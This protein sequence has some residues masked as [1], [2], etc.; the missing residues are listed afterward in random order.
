VEVVRKDIKNLHVG[1]Y[2]PSGR[3]RVA[4]PLRLGDDA[5]RL[6]VISRLGWIRRRQAEFEQ[7]DRQSQRQL[8]TGESH[9]FQGRRYRLDLVAHDGPPSVYRVN[10]TIMELRVRPGTDSTKREAVLQKWYR[11]RLRELLPQLL[12]KWERKVDVTVAEVR[13]KRMKTRWGSCNTAAGRIW[14]NLELAKKPPACLEYIL[15]HE[16]VHLIERHH[17]D[18]FRQCMDRVMPQWRLRREE[19]NR[20]PLSH[21]DWRY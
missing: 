18:R 8:V 12:A 5:V 9:Y 15:V 6:A 2:P 20:A 16:M 1:V 13:I 10:N 3:V 21:E 7:Q 11:G 17:T 19:L 14:L 4:A